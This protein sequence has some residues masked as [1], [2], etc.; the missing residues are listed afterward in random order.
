MLDGDC[1]HKIDQTFLV[2][3]EIKGAFLAFHPECESKVEVFHNI[4]NRERIYRL[5][6]LPGGFSDHFDGFRVV[7]LGRLAKQKALEVSIQAARLLKDAGVPV[8]WYVLGEGDQRA[9]LEKTIRSLELE[10]DF[11][12]PGT[13]KNPYPYLRQADLYVHAS[14]YEGKSIAIQEAQTLGCAMVVSDT[15]GNRIQVTQDQD[16]LLCSLSPMDVARTVGLLLSDRDRRRRLG[17]A[18][19]R[20]KEKTVDRETIQTILGL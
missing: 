8:R 2:S 7:T 11:L 12:L 16:G 5:S 10:E 18:A 3:D 19:A 13:V 14:R 9:F 1:Y 17:D 20:R 6:T 15:T 4:L